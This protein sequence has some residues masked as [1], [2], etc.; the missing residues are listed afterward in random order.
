MD[1][2]IVKWPLA[3]LGKP[4]PVHVSWSLEFSLI[5][6]FVFAPSSKWLLLFYF[7]HGPDHHG[8]RVKA[9][10]LYFVH[11]YSVMMESE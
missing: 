4:A 2:C 1:Y 11:V 10:L 9:L 5:T 7:G 6:Y 8:L 3:W